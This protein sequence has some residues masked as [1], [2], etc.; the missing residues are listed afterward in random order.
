MNGTVR[1]L[2]STCGK[3]RTNI[4]MSK[5]RKNISK[6]YNTNTNICRDVNGTVQVF[7]IY[8]VGKVVRTAKV[9]S[10]RKVITDLGLTFQEG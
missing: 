2:K 8:F 6:K 9:F 4:G 10:L 3:I 1:C 7:E 5:S